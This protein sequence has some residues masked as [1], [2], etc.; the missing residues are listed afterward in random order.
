MKHQYKILL[1][2][3]DPNLGFVIQDNLQL[4]GYDVQLHAD[5]KSAI[6]AFKP[7]LYQVILLDIMLPKADGFAVAR[8]IRD[9]D[10]EVPILFLTAKNMMEDKLEGFRTGAD[11]YITK[12]FSFEELFCRLEIFIKRRKLLADTINEVVSIGKYTFD[13]A[14]LKLSCAVETRTLTQREAL[15]LELL[16][17][18]RNNTLK[19]DEI[20]NQVWGDDD[21]FM[22]RSLD[23]FI[24]KLRKYLR[25][26]SA[27]QIQNQHGIGFSLKIES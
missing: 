10:K 2:E 7:S 13:F 12:P 22:G 4:R 26:D 14:K 1:V 23:V 18:N 21:Y 15:I 9:K 25:H 19:R 6:D 16:Y 17:R 5:G 8:F 27:V 3:D 24:S 11:D 20:L